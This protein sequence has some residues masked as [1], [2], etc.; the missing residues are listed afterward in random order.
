[1]GMLWFSCKRRR[2]GQRG[3]TEGLLPPWTPTSRTQ[4][5]R[6]LKIRAVHATQATTRVAL[7]TSQE[8]GP[9]S[10][11]LVN[12]RQSS[13]APKRAIALKRPE[14]SASAIP[15][16]LAAPQAIC[17]N[18]PQ[19]SAPVR[20]LLPNLRHHPH[21][22]KPSTALKGLFPF[23]RTIGVSR[24][25]VPVLCNC[26]RPTATGTPRR[27]RTRAHASRGLACLR[28]FRVGPRTARPSAPGLRF[29]SPAQEPG[30]GGVGVPRPPPPPQGS[31]Q[32][33]S[34][35]FGHQKIFPSANSAVFHRR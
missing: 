5:L 29:N 22:P 13:Q 30:G 23:C 2:A 3:V 34:G 33:F 24:E 7:D 8:P 31:G 20:P 9:A 14:A 26:R 28:G 6:A 25:P 11:G 12:P 21:P 18:P 17:A 27:Q 10:A 19:S 35:P 16:D 1:M 32:F 15:E 4:H